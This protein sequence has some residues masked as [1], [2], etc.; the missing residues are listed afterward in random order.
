M[1]KRLTDEERWERKVPTPQARPWQETPWWFGNVDDQEMEFPPTVKTGHRWPASQRPTT[2]LQAV[3]QA[4]PFA[5]PE[6]SLEELEALGDALAA[7]VDGLSHPERYVLEQTVI[8]RRS[9]R[10]FTYGEVYGADIKHFRAKRLIPKTTVA[11]LRDR[12]ITHLREQLADDPE[13][14][15]K[16]HP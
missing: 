3:M 14:K 10:E 4:A 7:A 1:T 15:A 11:R 8:A 12:A 9:L 13:V 2:A 16:L 5:E 6:T